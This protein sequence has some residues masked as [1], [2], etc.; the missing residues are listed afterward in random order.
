MELMKPINIEFLVHQTLQEIKGNNAG[1]NEDCF[2]VKA[3]I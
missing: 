1:D 3:E 2:A